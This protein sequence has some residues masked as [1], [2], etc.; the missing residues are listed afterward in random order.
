MQPHAAVPTAPPA[1][2]GAQ[3][4]RA[5]VH[6]A[7]AADLVDQLPVGLLAVDADGRATRWNAALSVLFGL[8]PGE[9]PDPA[10]LWATRIDAAAAEE[11]PDPLLDEALA[12][13]LT[14][15]D[16]RAEVVRRDGSLATL[17]L[18]TGPIRDRDGQRRGAVL[19]AA[20]ATERQE[21]EALRE[22]FL[23]VLSH[24][25]RTPVTSIFGGTELLRHHDLEPHVRNELLDDISAESER[26]HRVV[27]DLLV[28]ARIERGASVAGQDPVLLQR[29]VPSVIRTE[30]PHWPGT[31]FELH[32][33]RGLPAVR[34]EDGY[35]EQV[36]RNLLSNAAK[37]GPPGGLVEIEVGRVDGEVA[38][39]V[40]DRGPGIPDWAADDVFRLFYRV[41]G[42]AMG[43]P[44]AGIGLFVSRA[45]VRAMNGRIWIAERNGGGAEVGFAM[46]VYPFDETP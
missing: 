27:E 33:Q 19:V 8:D 14:R 3:S 30:Q 9:T 24:E 42:L 4:P 34:G 18:T 12:D 1:A 17:S 10:G 20:D 23:G 31:R 35:V 29:L 25:L 5:P 39:R 36:V 21:T 15:A 26:L 37:Y 2:R 40:L 11:R 16:V 32:L 46:Q 38:V 45:I 13:G 28:V 43:L 6:G 22:A 7:P 44:G 41:P